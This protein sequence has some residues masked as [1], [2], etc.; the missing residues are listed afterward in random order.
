MV[1]CENPNRPAGDEALD[2]LQDLADLLATEVAERAP[3]WCAMASWARELAAAAEE[4]CIGGHA[5]LPAA[6]TGIPP[7]PATA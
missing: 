4:R 2:R 5:F 7:P 6:A 3:D 1:A